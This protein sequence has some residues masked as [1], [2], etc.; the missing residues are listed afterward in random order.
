[1]ITMSIMIMIIVIVIVIIII[2]IISSSSSSSS[3]IIIISSS[4]SEP[5]ALPGKRWFAMTKSR[6]ERDAPQT[7]AARR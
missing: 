3:I 6:S 5:L 1:M 7:T 2:I 4:R